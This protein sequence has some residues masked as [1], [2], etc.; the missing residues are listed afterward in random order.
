MRNETKTLHEN[1]IRLRVIGDR[2]GFSEELKMA[3]V[4]AEQI[5]QDNT[6]LQLNIAF[7]YGG[8]WDI[9][10]ASRALAKQ[11]AAGT[12]LP[13][14]ISAEKFNEHLAFGDCPEPD[15]FIRTSG[16][17]RIS[18]FLLWQLAYTELYFTDTYFPDFREAQ[19]EDALIAYTKRQRRFGFSETQPEPPLNFVPHKEHA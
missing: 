1:N 2:S 9:I 6:G 8:R 17:Y 4:T 7:N 5:M 15:F 10:E 19:F 11:V 12:L 13:E 14:D 18:N 3:I 16:E